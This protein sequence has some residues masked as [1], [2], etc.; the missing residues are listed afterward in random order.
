MA[1]SFRYLHFRPLINSVQQFTGSRLSSSWNGRQDNN[2]RRSSNNPRHQRDNYGF[3]N[4]RDRRSD[5][6]RGYGRNAYQNY[7]SQQ[8]TDIRS[9]P[10]YG[11][12]DGDHLYGIAPVK[13]ALKAKR[14]KVSELLVQDDMDVENKKDSSGATEILKLAEENQIPI[15]HFSKHDLNMISDNRPHQGFILRAEPLQFIKMSAL[16]NQEAYK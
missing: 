10:V 12:Y 11:R 8:Q 15:R 4:S 16:E 7:R 13:L 14:R 1:L 5:V 9:E 3:D 6:K 2:D